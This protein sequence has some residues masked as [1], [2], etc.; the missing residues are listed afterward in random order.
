V[1]F[2]LHEGFDTLDFCGPLEMF[3]FAYHK[4]KDPSESY[5]SNPVSHNRL[6]ILTDL[7]RSNQS[8]QHHHCSSS[9]SRQ[10]RPRRHL[11]SRYRLRRRYRRHRKMGYP[12]RPRRHYRHCPK[13]QCRAHQSYQSFCGTA[14]K[15]PKQRTNTI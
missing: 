7:P 3:S 9:P 2:T 5:P 10:I 1:L 11:Q 6:V 13:R 15:R 12:R 14:E 4:L 8:L